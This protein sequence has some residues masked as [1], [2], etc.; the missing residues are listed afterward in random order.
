MVGD[1]D[2]PGEAQQVLF[3][4]SAGQQLVHMDSEEDKEGQLGRSGLSE[5]E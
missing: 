2:D 5:G 1:K 4:S 3:N